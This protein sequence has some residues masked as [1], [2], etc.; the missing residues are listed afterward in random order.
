[1]KYGQNGLRTTN[2]QLRMCALDQ[3]RAEVTAVARIA[4]RAPRDLNFC[5]ARVV[6]STLHVP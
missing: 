4:K 5:E 6:G 3:A 2:G 1:M